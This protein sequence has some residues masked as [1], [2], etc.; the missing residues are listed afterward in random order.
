MVRKQEKFTVGGPVRKLGYSEG[1]LCKFRVE[2]GKFF[3]VS[4]N[5]AEVS[6]VSSGKVKFLVL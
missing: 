3:D 1:E 2:L 4:G 6:R 5:S